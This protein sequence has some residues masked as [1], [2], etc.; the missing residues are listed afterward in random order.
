MFD[1][2]V[3]DVRE[4]R[5]AESERPLRERMIPI[6]EIN[7]FLITPSKYQ[8]TTTSPQLKYLRMLEAGAWR[9]YLRGTAYLWLRG[10]MVVY[11]WRHKPDREAAQPPVRRSDVPRSTI[12]AFAGV[13]DTPSAS[14]NS[15]PAATESSEAAIGSYSDA[16]GNSAA[17]AGPGVATASAGAGAPSHG[18]IVRSAREPRRSINPDNPFR[19]FADF[20][21]SGARS[22][23]EELAR[24][25]TAVAVLAAIVR[26]TSGG[27]DITYLPWRTVLILLGAATLLGIIN[28]AERV[29]K[30]VA[31]RFLRP[32]QWLRKVERAIIGKH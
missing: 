13:S 9:Q 21:V 29:Q 6:D 31:R 15:E 28:L 23:W 10:A 20:N 7:V 25:T 4:S 2:R 16:N 32:R 22:W 18:G 8:V 26:I 30:A 19:A 24:L 1:F 14:S 3:Y 11:Y 27:V 17:A 12:G 5:F